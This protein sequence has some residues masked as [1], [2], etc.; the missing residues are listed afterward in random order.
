MANVY[1]HQYFDIILTSLCVN[2]YPSGLATGNIIQSMVSI[3]SDSVT[4]TTSFSMAQSVGGS[5]TH[6]RACRSDSTKTIGFP[7]S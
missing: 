6:S 7:T 5:V 1:E 4:F 2:S 3:R